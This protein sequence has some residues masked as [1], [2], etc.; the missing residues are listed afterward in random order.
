MKNYYDILEISPTASEAEIKAAYRRLARSCHPD[1]A[2]GEA[3]RAKFDEITEAY[4]LLTDRI[5]RL[6]YDVN[7]RYETAYAENGADSVPS[8]SVSAN[9]SASVSVRRK[10][11][12]SAASTLFAAFAEHAENVQTSA[13]IADEQKKQ[14]ASA[15]K[16]S[17]K[18]RKKPVAKK[19]KAEAK[20][21]EPTTKAAEKPAKRKAAQSIAKS[22]RTP[23]TPTEKKSAS[24]AEKSA[25][26]VKKVR[27]KT[28]GVKPTE[29]K[30]K[31]ALENKPARKKT[32]V[33]ANSENDKSP[34]DSKRLTSGAKL[35]KAAEYIGVLEGQ[36]EKYEEL[37][38]AFM[39]CSVTPIRP[40]LTPSSLNLLLN[41][42]RQTRERKKTDI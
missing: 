2:E 35:K 12:R 11:V 25:K 13:E 20:P 7:L 8:A 1:V 39:R 34:S 23:A 27:E 16:P 37:I 5:S 3:A 15:I 38:H 4:K 29:K 36:L 9:K 22:E 18:E 42:N 32:A 19:I 14:T 26:S 6:A 30:G 10:K 24:V 21:P 28:S 33:A 40:E 31:A 41:V 17:D